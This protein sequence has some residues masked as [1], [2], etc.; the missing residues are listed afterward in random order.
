MS[1]IEAAK[2][3]GALPEYETVEIT[4]TAIDAA[5]RAA[6]GADPRILGYALDVL[7][8]RMP[9]CRKVRAAAARFVLDLGESLRDSCPWRFDAEAASRPIRFKEKFIVPSGDFDRFAELPWQCFFDGN[10]YGWLAKENGLLRFKKILLI[11]GSGNGKT[12]H[13]AGNALYDGCQMGIRGLDVVVFANSKNQSKIL[14]DDVRG[15]V[16][17]SADLRRFYLPQQKAVRNTRADVNL[18]NV[19]ANAKKLDG[20]R[21]GR[22][23]MDEYHEQ[24]DYALANQASRNLRKYDNSQLVIITTKGS[25]LDGPLMDEYEKGADLLRGQGN[26]RVGER[27]FFLCYEVEEGDDW[28]GDHSLWLKANPSL[29]SPLLGW[30]QL[31]LDYEDAKGTPRKM[32]DFITKT[33]NIFTKADEA[34]YLSASVVRRNRDSVEPAAYEDCPFWGGLDMAATEDHCSTGLVTRMADGRLL[35]LGH[36]FVPRATAERDSERLDYYSLQ[37]QGCLT[38]VDAPYIKQEMIQEWFYRMRERYQIVEIGYDPANASLL[39]HAMGQDFSMVP[40]RQ[41][42]L[43]FNEP[44][45]RLREHFID[46]R[47]VHN[48]DPLF[49]WYVNNVRLRHDYKDAEKQNWYPTKLSKHR[50]IDGFM[51]FMDAFILLLQRE[52]KEEAADSG[53]D[54]YDL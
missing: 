15:M 35:R 38:I 9:V 26:A 3:G 6:E 18:Y 30:E 48:C 53:I 4:G 25:V 41:G 46:G 47:V 43:T 29:G 52:M 19:A 7:E 37:M 33:L 27:T 39:A 10:V 31:E 32:S 14:M 49:Q 54:V 45:K 36:T 22:V 23:I 21:Y 50:K 34:S 2:G 12:G 1:L 17:R 42:P 20:P 51:A 40:V 5:R 28:R 24:R 44:M 13:V 11:V 8:E 16:E